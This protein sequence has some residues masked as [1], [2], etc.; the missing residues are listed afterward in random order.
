MKQPNEHKEKKNLK[1]KNNEQ[2]IN[3]LWDNTR[4]SN[5]HGYRGSRKKEKKK[6]A[7]KIFEEIT[8]D[9]SSDFV[10]KEQPTDR[11]SLVNFEQ[12]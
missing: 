9:R 8:V 4:S 1:K 5:L 12:K 7:E 3:N 6:Q 11:R 2:E 10:M